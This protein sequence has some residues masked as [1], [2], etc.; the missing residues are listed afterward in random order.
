MQVVGL[1]VHSHIQTKFVF[2]T[3]VEI[4]VVGLHVAF[5]QL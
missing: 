2:W 1:C 5:I 4:T 3:D